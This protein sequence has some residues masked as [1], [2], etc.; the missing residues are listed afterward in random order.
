M[1]CKFCV[2][3]LK[4][5]LGREIAINVREQGNLHCPRCGIVYQFDP[6]ENQDQ[7]QENTVTEVVDSSEDVS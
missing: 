6:D 1:A 3:P 2:V 7:C 4:R 5:A